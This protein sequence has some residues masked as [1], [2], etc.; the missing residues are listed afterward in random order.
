MFTKNKVIKGMAYLFSFVLIL[1]LGK[2]V[3]ATYLDVDN[4]LSIV[5]DVKRISYRITAENREKY[6]VDTYCFV[7]EK[8]H[9][10]ANIENSQPCP[11]VRSSQTAILK[12]TLADILEQKMD[13]TQLK[14][15]YDT[16]F[17]NLLG[18][19]VD[20][21]ARVI[22]LDVKENAKTYLVNKDRKVEVKF[23]HF[24]G[25]PK[26][27]ILADKV[28]GEKI[29]EVI[30]DISNIKLSQL[31]N[32]MFVLA[33]L[34]DLSKVATTQV[35]VDK[36]KG[37]ILVRTHQKIGYTGKTF[38]QEYYVVK[39]EDGGLRLYKKSY[40]LKK[41]KAVDT[42]A[43]EYFTITK[44]QHKLSKV[45]LVT[46]RSNDKT[47]GF[48]DVLLVLISQVRKAGTT[49]ISPGKNVTR[50]YNTGLMWDPVEDDRVLILGVG[51]MEIWDGKELK[52][53]SK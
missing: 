21:A 30:L 38:I 46:L 49:R 16:F 3:A 6:T 40:E 42:K 1:S 31:D 48:A 43:P 36:G 26:G 39:N 51:D 5:E 41:G 15:F 45:P 27:F 25:H 33:Q 44:K 2:F 14:E 50:I 24:V 13:S 7:Y 22:K 10:I 19:K 4:L 29:K 32:I 12:N 53:Y 47:K 34:S 37:K 11:V 23:N 8:A 52:N 18:P 17:N 35:E 20:P 9:K 28:K